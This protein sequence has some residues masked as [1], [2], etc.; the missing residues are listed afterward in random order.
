MTGR[1]LFTIRRSAVD[2]F[3]LIYA[4]LANDLLE[5]Y[6]VNIFYLSIYFL[7]KLYMTELFCGIFGL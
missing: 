3:H 1:K 4:A 6:Y 2:G 5:G 7:R